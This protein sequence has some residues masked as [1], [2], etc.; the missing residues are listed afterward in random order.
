MN[1]SLKALVCVLVALLLAG[2]PLLSAAAPGGQGRIAD[3]Q[4]SLEHSGALGR[5]AEVAWSCLEVLGEVGRSVF[6]WTKDYI[7]SGPYPDP[8]GQATDSGPYP[9][10]NG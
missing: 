1:R 5:A 9:D 2:A 4:L 6:A 10:P 7:E 8:N 3:S